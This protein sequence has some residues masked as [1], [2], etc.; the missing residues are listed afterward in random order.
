MCNSCYLFVTKDPREYTVSLSSEQYYNHIVSTDNHQAHAEFVP[1]EIKAC[2][3]SPDTI[4]QSSSSSSRDVYFGKTSSRYPMLNLQT[5]VS[6][7]DS[8]KTGEVVTAYLTKHYSGV[9]DGG[10]KYVKSKL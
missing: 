8:E 4:Y 3:E 7:N 2:I 5:V 6:V 1:D 9:K 10:L